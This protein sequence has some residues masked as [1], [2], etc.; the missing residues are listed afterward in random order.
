MKKL[1]LNKSIY[2]TIA[3]TILC[4]AQLFCIYKGIENTPFFNF[5]M[6]TE[7]IKKKNKIYFVEVDSHEI[8]LSKSKNYNSA[9]L[10]YQLEHLED[11]LDGEPGLNQVIHKRCEALK[12]SAKEA[13]VKEAI[14]NNLNK[15]QYIGWICS[16]VRRDY[17]QAKQIQFGYHIIDDNLNIIS[18]HYLSKNTNEGN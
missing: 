14:T 5:G 1:Q 9:V 11:I 12:I 6:F 7:P 8:N 3:I 10:L 4:I 15:H 2:I 16:Y 17:P 18:T 13:F